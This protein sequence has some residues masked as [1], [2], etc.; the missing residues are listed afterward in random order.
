MKNSE[1][2]IF[3][4]NMETFRIFVDGK[5]VGYHGRRKT[6]RT[7]QEIIDGVKEK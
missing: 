7:A 5:F 6:P 4:K 2:I 1:R 3:W